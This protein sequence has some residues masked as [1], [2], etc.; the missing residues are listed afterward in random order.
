MCS[1]S[2]FCTALSVRAELWELTAS[3]VCRMSHSRL[4][5]L[6]MGVL[7]KPGPQEAL[8]DS[9]GDNLSSFLPC[10]SEQQPVKWHLGMSHRCTE[11]HHYF[12]N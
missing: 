4:N 10:G 8:S 9:T 5:L 1:P 6:Q 2:I 11:Q 3:F 12:G 7:R